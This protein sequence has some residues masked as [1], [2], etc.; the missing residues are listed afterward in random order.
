MP[1]D[2]APRPSAADIEALLA[3]LPYFERAEGGEVAVWTDSHA[4]PNSGALTCGYPVYSAEV[5]AFI[6]LL[7]QPCWRDPHYQPAV[8]GRWLEDESAV[9]A[10]TLPQIRAMLTYTM[11]GERFCDGHWA[12]LA[13]RG[14]VA[15]LLRRLAALGNGGAGT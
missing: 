7:D 9:A 3:Y 15:R 5:H 12:G 13:R 14:R 8:A 11:R 10:A 6:R 1:R 2:A 4:D